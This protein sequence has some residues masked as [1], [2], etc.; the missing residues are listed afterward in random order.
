MNSKITRQLIVRVLAWLLLAIL[1]TAE[2]CDFDIGRDD[3]IK[4]LSQFSP[5]EQRT[6][7]AQIATKD[8]QLRA[9]FLTMTAEAQNRSQTETAQA[10]S[11]ISALPTPTGTP[12]FTPLPTATHTPTITPPPTATLTPTPTPTPSS[13]YMDPPNDCVE[14][15][16]GKSASCPKGFDIRQVNLDVK[17]CVLNISVTFDAP[18][19]GALAFRYTTPPGVGKTVA[20]TASY[21]GIENGNWLAWIIDANS[22]KREPGPVDAPGSSCQVSKAGQQT[23][24]SIPLQELGQVTIPLDS[25]VFTIDFKDQNPNTPVDLSPNLPDTHRIT[26]ENPNLPFHP[27]ANPWKVVAK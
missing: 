13:I 3:I 14:Y 16:S 18:F 11:A 17:D 26:L 15:T 10:M 1:T 27:I 6:L 20:D 12:T 23:Q 9:D 24:V 7:A 8:A 4:A 2:S 5:E 21:R 25:R 22:C 19:A